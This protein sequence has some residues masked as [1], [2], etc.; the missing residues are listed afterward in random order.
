MTLLTA[1][2]NQILRELSDLNFV[3]L[4]SREEAVNLWRTYQQ[5]E[6]FRQ[7]HQEAEDEL[8]RLRKE[9]QKKIESP[10]PYFVRQEAH[11]QMI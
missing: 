1:Q 6:R 9:Q 2:I 4:V 3:G 7:M 8:H 5:E 10:L 11:E